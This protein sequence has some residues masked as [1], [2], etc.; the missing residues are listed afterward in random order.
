[1]EIVKA[2]ARGKELKSIALVRKDTNL[3]K[4]TKYLVTEVLI[5]SFF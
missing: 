1:M 4:M 2:Y 3:T 5:L